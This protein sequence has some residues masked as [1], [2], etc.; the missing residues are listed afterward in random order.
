VGDKILVVGLVLWLCHSLSYVFKFDLV[1]LSEL[2]L[3]K[4]TKKEVISL[5]PNNK[6]SS[7]AWKIIQK[8]DIK[9]AVQLANL[10]NQ[11]NTDHL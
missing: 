3:P 1:V 9:L 10:L 7:D 11:V 8:Q 6:T 4:K 5:F 2:P